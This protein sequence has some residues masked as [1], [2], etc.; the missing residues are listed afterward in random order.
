HMVKRGDEL[1]TLPS[2]GAL[3]CSDDVALWTHLRR[4]K[5]R[6]S[7]I[8]HRE[9]VGMLGHR[10]RKASAR[11]SEQLG[12]LIGIKAFCSKQGNEVFVAELI[13]R[14][15]RGYVMFVYVVV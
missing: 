15:V 1:Q 8:P 13:E 10:S 4:I 2:D 14:S 3:H 11:L 7:G 6:Q 12:P 5:G 9:S